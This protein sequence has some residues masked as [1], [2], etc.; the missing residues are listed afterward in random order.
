MHIDAGAFTRAS[1]GNPVF[2]YDATFRYD[3]VLLQV[4]S[5]VPP[6]NGVFTLPGPFTYDVNFNEPVDPASVSTSSLQISGIPGATVTGAAVLPGATTVRFII[7]GASTFGTLNARIPVG[8]ITD[9]YGNPGAPFSSTYFVDIGTAPFP[10]PLKPE[11]P[12]GS[13]IY[14]GSTSGQVQPSGHADTF[15]LPVDPNQTITVLVQAS[16]PGLQ[17]TVQLVDPSNA[18]IGTATAPAPGQSALIQATATTSSSTGTYEIVVGGAGSTVG[19][20]TVQVTLN[21]ALKNAANPNNTLATAQPLD[22]SFVSLAPSGSASRGAVEGSN[23]AGPLVPFSTTDFEGAPPQDGY[24]VNNTIRGTGASAGL[25]HISTRRGTQTGHSPIHS[26]YYGSETTGTYDTGAANAGSITSPVISL[27]SGTVFFSF[28]YVLQ[29]EAS[30]SFDT[31]NVQISTDNF[32]TFTTVASRSTNLPNTATWAPFSADVSAF[33]GRDM[34]VRFVFDTIDAID[35]AHEGW[36]VDDVSF[37]TQSEWQNYYSVN[38]NAGDVVTVGLKDVAG[39]ATDVTLLDPS[40][41]TLVKGVAGPTNLDT[42]ISNFPIV[43]NPGKYYVLV[44]G[45]PAAS[46]DVVITRNA[47]FDS[48]PNNTS[49]TAQNIDGTGGVLGA[50]TSLTTTLTFDELPFQPVNGLTFKGVTF[51]YTV[52]GVPS[53]DAHYDAF[54]PGTTRYTQDPSLEGG[55]AGVLT[56][57]FAQPT[58]TLQFGVA[59]S[60]TLTVP[61]GATV[62]LFD[63]SSNLIGTST[64]LVAPFGFTF[65]SGLFTY[66]GPTPVAR[67]VVSFNSAAAARF[68]VDNLTFA[69]G[70]S[71]DWYSVDLTSTS[72]VLSL[73]TS[74]PA[75]GPGQFVNNLI[76]VIELYDPSGVRVATG[77]VGPDGRNQVLRYLASLPGTYRIHVTSQGATTGEFFLGAT[78]EGASPSTSLSSVNNVVIDNGTAQRSRVRSITVDFN[79]AI[80]SAPSAAFTVT[81]TEDGLVIPVIASAPTPLPGGKTRVTLTFDGPSLDFGSLADGF[82][83]LTIDGSQIIDGSGQQVDTGNNG[84]AGSTGTVSFHRFFGDFNGDAVVDSTDYLVF[85]SAY[86]SGDASGFNSAFNFDGSGTFGMAD[87]QA[88]T[89][90]FRKRRL[91]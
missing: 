49:G 19:T 52:N 20:Y 84:T 12:A 70:A 46:Y 57:N 43:T 82:Y 21:A 85:R 7:S 33:A 60:T 31:A 1:D 17:P 75:G 55:T 81:R 25:W 58:S 36:Y 90:N 11:A 32:K 41:N 35:N 3:A 69:T 78:T 38:L 61:N 27:P 50:I 40:G 51:G 63:A 77:T 42:A 29:T 30:A 53:S 28:N 56:L 66:V 14:D 18:V 79:G 65:S 34:Q 2:A 26:F 24:T 87:L 54:G 83:T 76:P 10:A 67:A 45:R 91:T 88:F 48:K 62:S 44:S 73:A 4:T 86:L 68:V 89:D 72:N 13:L 6:A 9:Q 23:P 8:A 15:T 47:A 64:V 80:A 5:T 16:G 71:E 37:A 22:G 74:T 59:L 39:T